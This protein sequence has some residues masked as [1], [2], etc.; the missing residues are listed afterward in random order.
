M[1]DSLRRIAKDR[2]DVAGV[3]VQIDK[4]SAIDSVNS[5]PANG[6]IRVGLLDVDGQ[7]VSI[8]GERCGQLIGGVQQPS[9]AGFGGKQQHL[10]KGNDASVVPRST[11]WM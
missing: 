6:D 9:I 3:L 11:A 2:A 5:R 10:A 4:S 7:G 1:D 8:A